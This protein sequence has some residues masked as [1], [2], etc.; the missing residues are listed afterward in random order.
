MTVLNPITSTARKYV[1][2]R[3]QHQGRVERGLDCIGLP[4]V[5]ARDLGYT[6]EDNVTYSMRPQG[7]VLLAYIGKACNRVALPD[8]QEGDLL[9]FWMADSPRDLPIHVAIYTGEGIIHTNRDMGAVVEHSLDEGDW[10]R[11][12]HSAWRFKWQLLP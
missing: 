11:R 3:F 7:E 4:V 10:R 6:V 2:T 5:V 1:G 12:I 9:A 8:M